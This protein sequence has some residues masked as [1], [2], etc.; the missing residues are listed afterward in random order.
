[1]S[2]DP[3]FDASKAPDGAEIAFDYIKT[4][5]FRCVW[6]DGVIGGITPRGLIHLATYIER[7][8]IP[9][10]QVFSIV[11]EDGVQ[12]ILGEEVLS[13]QVSRGSIVREMA[14]DLVMTPEVAKSI[15]AWLLMVADQ[16]AE[17]NDGEQI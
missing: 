4:P 11:S 1:M 9:R 7:P 13:K 2:D 12:G 14:L 6:V 8:S 15:A 5:D 16:I 10:R 17:T 3:V